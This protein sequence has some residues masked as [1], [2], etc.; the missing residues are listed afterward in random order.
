MGSSSIYLSQEACVNIV[1][2]NLCDKRTYP[3]TKVEFKSGKVPLVLFPAS[4][5]IE[6]AT[7]CVRTM[8]HGTHNTV[9]NILRPSLKAANIFINTREYFHFPHKVYFVMA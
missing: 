6:C 7:I 2:N 4:N 9:L 8:R 3:G 5:F 1:D